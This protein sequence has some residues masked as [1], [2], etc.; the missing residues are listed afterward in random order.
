M[1][2]LRNHL[3]Q[4]CHYSRRLIAGVIQDHIENIMCVYFIKKENTFWKNLDK[5]LV[6]G[7]TG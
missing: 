4:K 3:V 2:T 7:Y 1:C 5:E 6:S